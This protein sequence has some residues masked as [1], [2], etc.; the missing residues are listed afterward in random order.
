MLTHALAHADRTDR[1]W[2]RDFLAR[3]RERRLPREVL[4]LRGILERHGS[5][6]QAQRAAD[7]FA[8]AAAREFET[9]FAGVAPGPDLDW[10]RASV[11]YLV[12][13]DL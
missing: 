5:I 6:A 2:I 11:D 8:Q 10:L 9:A 7:A 3:P 12:R 1:A 4:R 13:R